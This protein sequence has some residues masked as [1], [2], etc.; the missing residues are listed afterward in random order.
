VRQALATYQ[1]S[2]LEA[3]SDV[4]TSL[5]SIHHERERRSHLDQSVASARETVQLIKD[6]NAEGLVDFQNVLDAE[7]TIF[8]N[9]DAAA[10]SAG[11]LADSYVSLYRSLGGGTRMGSK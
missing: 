7:R 4:E 11:L 1:Q 8:S 9:E 6:N 2:V 5:A 3:V 10:A